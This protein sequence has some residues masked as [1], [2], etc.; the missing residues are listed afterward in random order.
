[1]NE[2]GGVRTPKRLDD[3]SHLFLSKADEHHKTME[4]AAGTRRAGN[5]Q[6]YIEMICSEETCQVL[7]AILRTAASLSGSFAGDPLNMLSLK[8]EQCQAH[9][10]QGRAR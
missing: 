7:L 4:P 5:A 6:N 8:E 9:R 1:M 3:L 2:S 10:C